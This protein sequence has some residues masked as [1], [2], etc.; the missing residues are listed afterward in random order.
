MDSWL[1]AIAKGYAIR[2][3]RK[4]SALGRDDSIR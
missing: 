3:L 1:D 2:L 4:H